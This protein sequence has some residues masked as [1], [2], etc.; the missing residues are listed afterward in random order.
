MLTTHGML[1][2]IGSPYAKRGVQW[3]AYRKSFG[4]PGRVLVCKGGTRD[5]NPTVPQ[6]DIDAEIEDDEAKARA[7]YLAEFRDDVQSFLTPESIYAVTTP[8]CHERPPVPGTIYAAFVDAAGGSGADSM[9]MAVGHSEDD[10]PILDCLREARPPFSPDET[11][12]DFCKTLAKYNIYEAVGDRWGS[13]FVKEAFERHGIIYRT[14][15]KPKSDIYREALPLINSG[16]IDLLD[17]KRLTTQLVGLERRTA[18]G[19]KD[20]I[21]HA[22]NSH[23][24]LANACM[25]VLTLC[26]GLANA[27]DMDL[28]IYLQAF[29]PGGNAGSLI[30][31]SMYR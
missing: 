4:Q 31:R 30:R 9:T 7:E 5:F 11:V 1:I 21:D 8:D 26:A 16:R 10:C 23:D 15:E 20:S 13:G 24:D 28:Q 6:E 19:G 29:G 18:R 27:D 3:E 22:P 2:A 14:A 12:S 17:N 25:G